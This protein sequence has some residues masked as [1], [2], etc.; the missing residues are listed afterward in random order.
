MYFNLRATVKEYGRRGGAPT[1][2]TCGRTAMT[3]SNHATAEIGR[4]VDEP[5]QAPDT[6]LI[7]LRSDESA[8]VFE[9]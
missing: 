4:A 3:S 1:A 5:L 7:R 2:G 8:A 6:V 9:L